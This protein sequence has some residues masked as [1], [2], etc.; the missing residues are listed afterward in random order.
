MEGAVIRSADSRRCKVAIAVIAA[1]GS[2]FVVPLSASPPA[3][4]G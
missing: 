1:F 2:T 4:T 3:S